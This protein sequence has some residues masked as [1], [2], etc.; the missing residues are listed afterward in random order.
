MKRLLAYL[1]IVFALG[2]TLSAN[3]NETYGT[4]RVPSTEKCNTFSKGD[5]NW[6]YNNCDQLGSLKSAIKIN[7]KEKVEY[8]KSNNTAYWDFMQFKMNDLRG[9]GIVY[10][11]F[12]VDKYY[13]VNEKYEVVSKGS[14]KFR[15]DLKIYTLTTQDNQ[16]FLFKISIASQVVDIKSKVY[17]YKGYR[18]YQLLLADINEQEQIRSSLENFENNKYAKVDSNQSNPSTVSLKSGLVISKKQKKPLEEYNYSGTFLWNYSFL[19]DDLRGDGPVY[20]IFNIDQYHRLD[21]NFNVLSKGT[22]IENK[23]VFELTEDEL[24]FK[25]KISLVDKIVDIKS[26]FYDYKGYRRYQIKETTDKQKKLVSKSISQS[27]KNE[28]AKVDTNKDNNLKSGMKINKD[29]KITY[30]KIGEKDKAMSGYGLGYFYNKAHKINDLR[31]DGVVYYKFEVKTGNAGLY[32]RLNKDHEV[33]SKGNFQY[34]K[35]KKAF[36]LEEDNEIFLWRVSMDYE[37]VDIN[38]KVYDYKGYRRYQYL[39]AEDDAQ[40]KIYASIKNF[41]DGKYVKAGSKENNKSSFGYE[42]AK[43]YDDSDDNL[44]RLWKLILANKDIEKKYLKYS[45]RNAKFKGKP[46]KAMTLAVFIDYK[47]ELSILTKDINTKKLSSP[48]AWGWEY[49]YEDP[50]KIKGFNENK[51]VVGGFEAIRNCYKSVR[52]KKLSLRDGECILVD[53]RRITTESQYPVIWYNYLI[54]SKNNIILLAEASGKSKQQIANEKKEEKKKKKTLLSAQKKAE[55]ETKKQEKILLAKKKQLEEKKEALILAQI[56]AIEKKTLKDKARYLEK[57]MAAAFL[58]SN[59]IILDDLRGNGK[60]YYQFEKDKY[61]RIQRDGKFISEG[62]FKI[63]GSGLI[64]LNEKKDKFYWK[65]SV[66]DGVIDI[67]SK[68]YP[69]EGYKRFALDFVYKQIAKD[70]RKD[71]KKLAKIQKE[72]E[73]LQK[74]EIQS[75]EEKKVKEL[76]L[77]QKKAEEETKKQ[78]LLLAQ[79]KAEEEKKKQELLLAEEKAEEEKKKQELIAQLKDQEQKKLSELELAKKEAEKEFEK[80]KKELNIDQDSPEIIVAEA[81]TVS[82]QAYKLKGKV[83]DKSDFFLEVDGQPVKVNKEGEFLFEGFIIDT[84][85]GEELTIVAVDRWNNATEKNIK[86]NV[87]LKEMKVAK[88]YEKLLPNKISVKNDKN[89]IAIIIGVEKYEYLTN[90][91]A[92]FANRDANAFREYAVRALGVDPSNINLLVDEGASRPKI[93]KALKLW[94][95]KIG[96]ENR[97]IYLF[98][99]G[100]G[101]ASDD[102]KNLYILPQDGD[103]SL[104][105]DTAITRNEI[106]KI[107][108]KTNPKSVTMFFDTCYSGQTRN[109]ETL[110]ASLRPVRIVADDQAIPNNFTIFSASANDQTSGSIEEAKHGMFSYY[111]MKG[112]EGAADENEDNKISNGELIAYIQN[113]VSKVAFSQNREQDPGM[114]GDKDKILFSYK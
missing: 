105:E 89:K 60:V 108:Q 81:I 79:K 3:S 33:I 103:A 44:N 88:G 86:I 29:K 16:K 2:L 34:K 47:K 66:R 90:L 48:I 45:K 76:L 91:D 83:K 65:L 94:L 67:K 12:D 78:E 70:E 49:S 63:S 112:M 13:R 64:V 77:A 102:G 28:Y 61:L 110:V 109:E 4:I 30:L 5:T 39:E 56:E 43:K 31:G 97:D 114:S 36:E 95:P 18:R 69:Y 10:Y 71:I 68:F 72:E 106:I 41:E 6:Y 51:T 55:E 1:F 104:L 75:Q 7:K 54:E 80:K 42:I 98:F 22:F 84:I 35:K 85:A 24:K 23:R 74:K 58:D 53:L 100:H 11:I 15:K 99:A 46:I 25:W 9:D 32:Y 87:K 93:L 38:S 82:S 20:Y 50:A 111:L 52:K 14:Y 57:K 101:L 62:Q 19:I 17:D 40:N 59:E 27:K 113:N 26:T 8:L 92:A 96:G 21:K 37:I 73:E 107:L